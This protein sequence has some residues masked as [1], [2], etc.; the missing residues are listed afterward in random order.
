[1]GLCLY[2]HTIT[3]INLNHDILHVTM[4]KLFNR[5]LLFRIVP[6]AS[7]AVNLSSQYF[8]HL[9]KNYFTPL[10]YQSVR[11]IPSFEHQGLN[12]FKYIRN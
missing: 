2:I 12:K 5:D 8:G 6:Q 4:Y 9:H 7:K 3:R 1:M 10:F 11:G